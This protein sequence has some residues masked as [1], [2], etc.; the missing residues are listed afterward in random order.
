MDED[1]HHKGYTNNSAHNQLQYFLQQ[2]KA[3]KD[4]KLELHSLM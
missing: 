4:L 1:K 3:K 2:S